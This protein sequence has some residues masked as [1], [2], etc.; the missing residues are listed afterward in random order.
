[1]IIVIQNKDLDQIKGE[2]IKYLNKICDLKRIN[3]DIESIVLN[4]ITIDENGVIKDFD[5]FLEE[6]LITKPIKVIIS[7]VRVPKL[8]EICNFHHISLIFL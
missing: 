6:V 2:N 5:F 1:M 8:I 3:E 4:N 7:N